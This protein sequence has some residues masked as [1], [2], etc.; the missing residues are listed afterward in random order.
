M[1]PPSNRGFL[2]QE[3][4]NGSFLRIARIKKAFFESHTYDVEKTEKAL[5]LLFIISIRSTW[6]FC[7]GKDDVAV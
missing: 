6:Y 2:G 5:I 4:Q 7:K 3:P 1:E